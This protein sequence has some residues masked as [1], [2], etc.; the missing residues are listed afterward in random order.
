MASNWSPAFYFSTCG[1]QKYL[2]K[3]THVNP[4][5]RNP[6]MD[7]CGLENKV[8]KLQFG[9]QRPP[10]LD[11]NFSTSHPS[12]LCGG[13]TSHELGTVLS[14]LDALNHYYLTRTL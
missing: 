3:A 7:P 6:L 13:G 5:L 12:Q 11:S 9:I 10:R 4:L 14:T 2:W 1:G 8:V